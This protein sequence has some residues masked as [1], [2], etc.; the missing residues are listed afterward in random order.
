MKL[1]MYWAKSQA[2]RAKRSVVI[3]AVTPIPI[4]FL[5]G[6][7]PILQLDVGTMRIRLPLA[8]V[9]DFA[10]NGMVV[11]IIGIVRSDTDAG[12]TA[13]KESRQ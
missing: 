5:L 7:V 11:V 2:V 8:V 6:F 4:F 9:N 1:R 13:C 10:V 3:G 12:G